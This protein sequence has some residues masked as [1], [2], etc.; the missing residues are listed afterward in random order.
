MD[1]NKNSPQSVADLL[2]QIDFL[3]DQVKKLTARELQQYKLQEKLDFQLKTQ[4][5]IVKLGHKIQMVRDENEIAA[6]VTE[7]LVE[8]FE[9]EKAIFC[10]RDETSRKL[11]LTGMEGYYGE[12]DEAVIRQCLSDDLMAVIEDG[13]EDNIIVQDEAPASVLKMDKRVVL[14][15]RSKEG[16]IKHLLV[17][18][19]SR[20]KSSCYR[21]ISGQDRILWETIW[22]MTSAALENAHLN[23][24]L[25]KEQE[26]LRK[27][28]DNLAKLNDELERIVQK[29][30]AELARSREEYRLLYLEAERTST[31]FRSLID[32]TADPIIVYDDKD[33]SV[34]V[35]PAFVRIF[36]WKFAELKDEKINFVPQ[37]KEKEAAEIMDLITQKKEISNLETKRKTKDGRTRDVSISAAANFDEKGRYAG[38][39]FQLRDITERKLLEAE[40]LKMHKL[41]SIGLL[42]G[43]IA[44]D[45][46]NILA[47][48]L[49]NTQMALMNIGNPAEAA[50]FLGGVEVATERAA[51]LARQLLTFAKGGAPVKKSTS[52][53]KFIREIVEFIL[54]GSNVKCEFDVREVIWPVEID[55]GQMNQVIQN[56]IINA[57]QSMP[58][59][60]IIRISLNNITPDGKLETGALRAYQDMDFVMIS[61]RDTGVGIPQENLGK[62]FD[63]YFTTKGKN[64]G[65]GLSTA[66]SIITRHNGHIRVESTEGIGS[67]FTIYLPAAKEVTPDIK[68]ESTPQKIYTRGDFVLVMDDEQMIR[69]LMTAMLQNMGYE[70]AQAQDGREAIDLYAKAMQ[71]GKPHD[72]VI[73][74]LTIP[75]GMGGKETITELMAINRDIKAVVSSGYSNDPIMADYKKYGFCGVLKKPFT[76]NELKTILRASR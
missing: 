68:P 27:A 65:I 46:N 73:M 48:I 16:I 52:I 62:I 44:H 43:G 63:P 59:G 8:G 32:S 70:V 50:V 72:L 51:K 42:A 9:Y 49:M 15:Y 38:C 71:A 55:E 60:G 76:I 74:D 21:P 34:Y 41:E 7:T 36:G 39:V 45:F 29:R 69:E 58:H 19:N 67:T 18:G 14:V 53:E 31:K 40:I 33:T 37:G 64:T 26:D 28:H 4:E 66:Y 61:I 24:Q 5:E 2:G 10:L 13:S 12:T 57:Q 54:R 30:T 47:A 56:L 1:V 22:R 23:K 20:D 35:N 17:F 75:G 25:N 11:T 6:I 3:K